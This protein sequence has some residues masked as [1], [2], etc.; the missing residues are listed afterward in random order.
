[1]IAI[2]I[3]LQWKMPRNIH[4]SLI[5]C[6]LLTSNSFLCG[7]EIVSPPATKEAVKK[8]SHEL[9]AQE[10]FAFA[11]PAV[12]QVHAYDRDFK[13]LGQGSGFL[14]SKQGLIVTNF[15]VIEGAYFAFAVT[16]NGAWLP[17]EG[18]LGFN[19]SRDVALLLVKLESNQYL[20]LEPD[21]KLQV[22]ARV[23][24][25]GTP[26]GLT[27]T[28]SEGL[29]SGLRRERPA[30]GLIQTTAPISP[31]SSGGPLLLPS[32]KVVGITTSYLAGGQN[33]NFAVPASEAKAL[34][35][36]QTKLSPLA[37]ATGN[38]L[39]ASFATGLGEF[40][41]A[42][43]SDDYGAALRLILKLRER[44]GNSAELW[45]GLGYVHACLENDELAQD[46]YKSAISLN[47][48]HTPS[49]HNLAIL[50]LK[51][52]K[53][54][55]AIAA[56]RTLIMLSPDDTD[57]LLNFSVIAGSISQQKLEADPESAEASLLFRESTSTLNMA[58]KSAP[59]DPRAYKALGRLL[60]A[61]AHSYRLNYLRAIP[62]DSSLEVRQIPHE[63]KDR[64]RA[65]EYYRKAIEVFEDGVKACEH[66]MELL[67]GLVDSASELLFLYSR[68]LGSLSMSAFAR[69]TVMREQSQ[70]L[71]KEVL[72]LEELNKTCPSNH[73]IAFKLAGEYSKLADY[74]GLIWLERATQVYDAIRTQEPNDYATY[75]CAASVYVN[76]RLFGKAV[77]Y[78]EMAIAKRPIDDQTTFLEE[79]RDSTL[80]RIQYE[81]DFKISDDWTVFPANLSMFGELLK[82]RTEF[83][84]SNKCVDVS[85]YCPALS[86]LNSWPSTLEELIGDR[87]EIFGLRPDQIEVTTLSDEPMAIRYFE[88]SGFPILGD[89]QRNSE[90]QRKR[91]L[92]AF[93]EGEGG[94]WI[95]LATGFDSSVSTK[96]DSFQAFL[97]SIRHRD[98]SKD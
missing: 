18:H 48:T 58:R 92:A 59:S 25:I 44:E 71:R 41:K 2:A 77:Q 37:S 62:S 85:V 65:V 97:R 56:L 81:I 90:N 82:L 98:Y 31:G 47:P 95:V 4:D 5:V 46:A 27:N 19:A 13:S 28:L 50:Y 84:D 80:K 72:A 7:S 24:A 34:I 40:W 54:E 93:I 86:T 14:V 21:A 74:E 12:L 63:I 26:Q 16:S 39:E 1:M 57:A 17:I 52:G 35:S 94:P 89:G 78:Y 9:S 3:N 55:K 30:T 10:L 29:V 75:S 73:E 70:L 91:H 49:Y 69:E 96:R 88:A 20:E 68:E 11:S 43:E 15:H 87:A 76:R 33:L 83:G 22:G 53:Q 38:R 61:V 51:S 64:E 8:K 67:Q 60:W 6:L 42:I 23:F 66:R 32:G 79:K 45:F 36:N